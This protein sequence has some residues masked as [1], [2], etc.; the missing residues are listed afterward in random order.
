MEN[1]ENKSKKENLS[2]PV[3]STTPDR[4]TWNMEPF[5]HFL[6]NL[7]GPSIKDMLVILGIPDQSMKVKRRF[8]YTFIFYRFFV[9]TL[10]IVGKFWGSF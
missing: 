8:M 3:E 1:N 7:K 10:L 6:K 4:R 2:N 5:F 9:V